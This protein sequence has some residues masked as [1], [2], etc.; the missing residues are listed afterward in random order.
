MTFKGRFLKAA[1][2]AIKSYVQLDGSAWK[3]GEIL[4]Q[5]ETYDFTLHVI[6]MTEAALGE[7]AVVSMTYTDEQSA[8][9]TASQNGQNA[10]TTYR[11]ELGGFFDLDDDGEL[12]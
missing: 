8:L 1:E 11:W 2:D 4:P 9:L 6:T 12:G 5:A 7:G 10:H 3:V